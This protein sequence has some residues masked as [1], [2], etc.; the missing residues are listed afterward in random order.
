MSCDVV[1]IA[2]LV[3][4][5]S[6]ITIFIDFSCGTYV[7][8]FQS[9]EDVSTDNFVRGTFVICQNFCHND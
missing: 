4:K 9:G 5:H 6:L 1:R 8:M 3:R 2:A 7:N